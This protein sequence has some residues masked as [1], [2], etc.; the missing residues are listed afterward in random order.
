MSQKD[1]IMEKAKEIAIAKLRL[2]EKR[3]VPEIREFKS[4]WSPGLL[5]KIAEVEVRAAEQSIVARIDEDTGET[6]GW[7]YPERTIGGRVIKLTEEE[8]VRIAKSEIEIPD[9]A[10]LESVEFVNRGSPGFSCL[11]KWK[12][13]VNNIPVEGD[14]VVVKINPETKAVI[15]AT[16][17][18]SEIQ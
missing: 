6:V 2:A 1:K 7:R 12:H 9:D 8:A 18:W 5:R 16:K 4:S 17:N 14:F 10:I 13:V 11:V 3:A 15:S